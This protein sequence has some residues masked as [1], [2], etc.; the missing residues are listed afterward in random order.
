[1]DN[2]SFTEFNAAAFTKSLVKYAGLPGCLFVVAPDVVGD[3][4]ATAIQFE[5]WQDAIRRQ[6]YPVALAAQDGLENMTIDWNSFDA[7]FIG[8]TNEFK[9]S[10]FVAELIY[11]ARLRRKWTHMGRVNSPGRWRYC[12]QLGFD[13]C[14]GTGMVIERA[15]VLEALRVLNSP[16]TALWNWQPQTP[17]FEDQ[18]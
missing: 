5:Q 6:G 11:E 14:D 4:R 9:F 1:M 2:F 13:S 18:L 15:R 17:V 12:A 16:E 8:G 3:A 7:L 10:P